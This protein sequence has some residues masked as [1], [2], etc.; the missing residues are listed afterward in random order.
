MTGFSARQMLDAIRRENSPSD[1]GN[2]LVS[3]IAAGKAS[4]QV[5]AAIAGEQGRVIESDLRS[6]LLLSAR[7]VDA[8]L[9]SAFFQTLAHGEGIARER[10]VDYAAACG[11]DSTARRTY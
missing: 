2:R 11:L 3:L 8:P 9:T 6:L 5:L 10:L 7:S 1:V 4:L